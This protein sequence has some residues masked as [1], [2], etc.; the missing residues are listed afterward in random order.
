MHLGYRQL[1]EIINGG[2]NK[3]VEFKREIV[4]PAK[5][6][7]ELVAFA[8]TDGG[9]LIVGVDDDKSVYG[10]ASE[11]YEIERLN[12]CCEH[13]ID[14]PIVPDILI[15][16]IKRKYLAVCKIESSEHKPHFLIE[17]ED[18]NPLRQ[19]YIRVGESSVPASKEMTRILRLQQADTKPLTIS[20]GENERRIFA[21]LEEHNRAKIN[22]IASAL[23]FSRRR[24]NRMVVN[25]VRAKSLAIHTDASGDY[26][27]LF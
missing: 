12:F 3:T 27:T 15:T 17:D 18:G 13:L 11:K 2:E 16:D 6:A 4:S 5:I 1:I 7:K 25:L 26:Y 10:V 24:T 21:Y 22:D 14:P 19:A 23:N 9:Y 8:N 20:I